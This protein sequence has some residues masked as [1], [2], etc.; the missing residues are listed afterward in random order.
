MGWSDSEDL[1]CVQDD[2]TV[3]IHDMFGNY[4]HAFSMG[5]EAKD[6]KILR[7]KIFPS[8]SGTG[9]AVMTKNYRVFLVNNIKE[10]QS[11]PLPELPSNYFL[12]ELKSKFVCKPKLINFQKHFWTQHP[13]K[14]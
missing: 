13:G 2:G 11:K 4:L 1:L 9:I 6:T 3:L 8:N 14:L 12:V 5:Q 10:P 7:A